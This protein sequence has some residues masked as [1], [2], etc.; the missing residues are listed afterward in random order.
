MELLANAIR[1][2]KSIKGQSLD[3]KEFKLSQYAND[4][5][6][7]VDDTSSA[8]NLFEKLDLFRLYVRGSTLIGPKQRHY[9]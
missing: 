1:S 7:M 9:G 6:C 8:S 2:D 4:T 3:S 5:T